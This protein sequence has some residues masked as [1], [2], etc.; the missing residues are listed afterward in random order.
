MDVKRRVYGFDDFVLN[1]PNRTLSHPSHLCTAPN[2]VEL[3]ALLVQQPG[4]PLTNEQLNGHFWSNRGAKNNLDD[5]VRRLRRFFIVAG[6]DPKTYIER[7]AGQINFSADVR[8]DVLKD[9]ENSPVL[10]I[11]TPL[12]ESTPLSHLP[13]QRFF[14]GRDKELKIIR[15]AIL[16]G[17]FS[18]GML[19]YGA[20]GIGKTSLALRA[21]HLAPST[22][23]SRKLFVS[24][25]AIELTSQGQQSLTDFTI[26]NYDL[27]LSEIARQLGEENVARAPE[28]ERAS[29]VRR[30]LVGKRALL[31]ID[32]VETFSESERVRLYQF[33]HLLPH[34]CRAIVTSRNRDVDAPILHVRRM[35]LEDTLALLTELAKSNRRLASAGINEWRILYTRTGGNPLLLGWTVG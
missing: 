23:Y 34:D 8:I 27:L 2:V 1:V 4:S 9:F 29:A 18:W 35:E 13:S 14:V 25:Q 17:S 32:N 5:L 7:R 24:A 19:V 31:V 21:A 12:I 33:L 28:I 6:H 30:A 16:P 11:E 26:P 10:Q 20:G 15:E 3:A 22:H